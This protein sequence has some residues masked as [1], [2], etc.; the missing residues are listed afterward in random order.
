MTVSIGGG[1]YLAAPETPD[2][3]MAGNL[4]MAQNISGLINVQNR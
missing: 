2:T 3:T 4:L 1:W